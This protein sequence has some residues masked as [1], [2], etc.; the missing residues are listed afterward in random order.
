MIDL[1]LLGSLLQDPLER[2]VVTRPILQISALFEMALEKDTM[3]VLYEE[4]CALIT[5]FEGNPELVSLLNNPQIVKEEKVSI[6]ERIFAGKVSEGLM[7]LLAIIVEKGRQN[8]M[9]S[10]FAYFVQRVKEFKKIGSVCVTSAV[11]LSVGQKERLRERLLESTGYVAFEMDYQVDPSLIGG[12][13]VRIGDR[14]VDN[15]IKT[16]LYQLKKELLQ[17][18]LA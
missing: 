5:I 16:R 15:S 13:T 1:S 3:D 9:L 14:V 2:G 8:D 7:G 10:I 18:Q 12:M 11:E 6:M 4:A 17:L